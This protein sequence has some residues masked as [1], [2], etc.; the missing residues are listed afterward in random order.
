MKAYVLYFDN[1]VAS[2]RTPGDPRPVVHFSSSPQDWTMGLPQALTHAAHLN[3]AGVHAKNH[4]EHTCHFEIEE[5][6]E[7]VYVIVCKNHP[8]LTD[9]TA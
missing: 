7:D 9:S 4:P 5:V 8:D 3:A 6:D 1:G 2:P